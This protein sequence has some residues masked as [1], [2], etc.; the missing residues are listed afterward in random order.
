MEVKKENADMMPKIVNDFAETFEEPN[1]DEEVEI[2]E[3]DP[4]VKVDQNIFMEVS[5]PEPEINPEEEYTIEDVKPKRQHPVSS[6]R[7]KK[8]PT[9]KQ[10]AAAKLRAEKARQKKEEQ[11]KLKKQVERLKKENAELKNKPPIVKEIKPPDNRELIADAVKT[12]LKEQETLR[13]QRKKEKKQK[14]ENDR[15]F[16]LVSRSKYARPPRKYG[17]NVGF[18]N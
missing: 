14:V 11:E 4:K 13:L 1:S 17:G 18:L 7:K 15:I 2:P 9:E 16:D 3:P 6:G 5:E 12:A 8:Q 10:L